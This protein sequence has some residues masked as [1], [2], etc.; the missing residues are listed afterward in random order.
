[1]DVQDKVE[2]VVKG[3]EEFIADLKPFCGNKADWK[4]VTDAIELLKA[5]KPVY[6]VYDGD[7]D[8]TTCSN[9]GYVLDKAYG[10]CPG[11]GEAVKWNG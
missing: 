3:L 9:C 8:W 1:M 6:P 10:K 7:C 4:K 5:Q 11:C 2:T